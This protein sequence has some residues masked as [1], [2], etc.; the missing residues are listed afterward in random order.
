MKA[1]SWFVY[2]IQNEKGHYYTGITTDLERRL[3]E[4]TSS[5]KGA[6]FFRTGAPVDMVFTKK[7]ANRSLASKFEAA[8]KKL[9][10]AEKINLVTTRKVKL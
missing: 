4:H 8:V 1:S 3:K 7:F 2:I 5:K 9:S 10:R 6:K